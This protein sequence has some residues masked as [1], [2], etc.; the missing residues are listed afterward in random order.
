[1]VTFDDVVCAAQRIVQLPAT[2]KS[3][4]TDRRE[5][6]GCRIKD[7]DEAKMEILAEEA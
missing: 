3:K 6:A 7:G 2:E 5:A 4:Q 1:M